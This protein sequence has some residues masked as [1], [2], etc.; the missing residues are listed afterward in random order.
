MS[1]DNV[2]AKIPPCYYNWCSK[3]QRSPGY[4]PPN[5]ALERLAR[6]E[7]REA[8]NRKQNLRA[9]IPPSPSFTSIR[10]LDE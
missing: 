2:C 4:Y 9:L 6:R 10:Y 1:D 8:E 5:G 7:L 3:P